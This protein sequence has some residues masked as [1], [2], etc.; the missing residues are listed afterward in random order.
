MARASIGAT[1]AAQP[2]A[3]RK[4]STPLEEQP[5]G[6]KSGT[7]VGPPLFL[8]PKL[9]VSQPDD[10][11]ER[12]ADRVAEDVMRMPKP[13]V[14]RPCGACRTG[15][16][17]CPACDREEPV[18]LSRK[19]GATGAGEVPASVY[20]VIRSPGQPLPSPV[21]AFFEPHFGE[22]FSDVRVHTDRQAQQ[23]ARD[24]HAI[25]YTV[26]SN[27]VFGAGRYA[28]GTEEGQRLL[29][30]ELTHVRQQGSGNAPVNL[31]SAELM[32]QEE[33]G[34]GAEADAAPEV[35]AESCPSASPPCE[36]PPETF[37]PG[38]TLTAAQVRQRRT[39][40]QRLIDRVR[41]STPLAADN[42]HHWLGNSGALRSMPPE[43]FQRA[44]SG[45]A[46][47]LRAVHWPVIR[48]GIV[49]RLR[50]PGDPESLATAGTVRTLHYWHSI[51][52]LPTSSGST[53]RDLSIALGT[54]AVTAY[55]TVRSTGTAADI[56]SWCV[57]VCDRYDWNIGA[58][59][60]VPIPSD[61]GRA[62]A[63][64]EGA[65]GRVLFPLG[66]EADTA[67]YLSDDDWFRDLETSGGGRRYEVRTDIF[68][69]PGMPRAVP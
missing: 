43:P 5:N 16:S 31:G 25:A 27:V 23:S 51:A 36:I 18:M 58:I 57:Q 49:R 38:A 10:P 66:R 35:M 8:H 62:I 63:D 55:V 3:S 54:Y 47:E 13:P 33:E 28:P 22:D 37:I 64:T 15:G 68:S 45:V 26:G 56:L 2:A 67:F 4:T 61:L 41:S 6:A 48:A 1:R 21:R 11:E 17:P 39:V 32:R 65:P 53:E 7:A 60:P 44:D 20:S 50:D 29:A 52:A 69:I 12:E 30:H 14:Q 40:V 24:V 19:A 9:S 34:A 46:R 42:L 59:A